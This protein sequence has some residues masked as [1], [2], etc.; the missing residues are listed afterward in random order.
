MKKMKRIFYVLIGVLVMSSCMPRK[1][2]PRPKPPHKTHK[3][4]KLKKAPPG[5]VKKIMG[6]KSA[7]PYAP[8]QLKNKKGK[9]HQKAKL[10]KKWHENYRN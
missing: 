3:A 10:P 6:S 7:K 1:H 9:K 8:G 2:P 5:Q 4:H